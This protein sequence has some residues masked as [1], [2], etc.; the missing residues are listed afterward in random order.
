MRVGVQLPCVTP[1]PERDAVVRIA[2]Q[3]EELGFD[4]VWAGDHLVMPVAPVSGYPGGR[5]ESRPPFDATFWMLEPL[6]VLSVVAGCT[7]RVLLGTCILVMPYRNPVLLAKMLATLDVVSGGRVILGAG[8]GWLKKEEFEALAAPP[9]EARGEVTNEWIAIMRACWTENQ[10]TFAGQYYRLEP[11]YCEPKPTR[12]I[13]V[14]IG[15]NSR[16]AL[17]RTGRLGDG[18]LGGTLDPEAVR[19]AV[20]RARA[21]AHA[22]GRDPAS[23]TFATSGVLL[24]ILDQPLERASRR[25]LRGT[26]EEIA[27]HLRELERAGIAHVVLRLP[28]HFSVRDWLT[29]LETFAERVRPLL[30]G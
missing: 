1:L 26:P 27:E 15:G 4:S 28:N 14:W 17:R 13:P 24:Q 21:E 25:Y 30:A 20:A 16:A 2:R 9:Y 8:L 19:A 7:S 11:V 22:A 6:T 18:W 5:G 23:L 12:S 10:V 3:A 29:T